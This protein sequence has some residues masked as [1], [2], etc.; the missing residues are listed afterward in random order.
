VKLLPIFDKLLPFS[1]KARVAL[2]I[3]QFS[4][5]EDTSSL[6]SSADSAVSGIDVSQSL[7]KGLMLTAS[8]KN[9][10]PLYP[11]DDL[12][13]RDKEDELFLSQHKCSEILNA[14]SLSPELIHQREAILKNSQQWE[15]E[16]PRLAV[17][18]DFRYEKK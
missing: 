16:L 3:E 9:L 7:F 14:R 17:R 4:N 2:P 8:T 1:V 11:F 6:I 13:P 18:F 10:F 12:S 5:N 15:E